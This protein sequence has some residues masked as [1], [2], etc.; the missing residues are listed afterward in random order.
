MQHI[1]FIFLFLAIVL[2]SVVGMALAND[3]QKWFDTKCKKQNSSEE[4]YDAV[5]T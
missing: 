5:K 3:L 2:I 1:E 4:N